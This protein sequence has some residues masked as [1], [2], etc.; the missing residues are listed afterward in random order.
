[1]D[2]IKEKVEKVN[3]NRKRLLELKEEVLTLEKII[4]ETEENN[5][6]NL[7]EEEYSGLKSAHQEARKLINEIQV[8]KEHWREITK[9]ILNE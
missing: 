5:N 3:A 8:E 4:K 1:M 2:S 7:C 9:I 6:E